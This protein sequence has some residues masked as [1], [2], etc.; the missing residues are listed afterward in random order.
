[1]LSSTNLVK[2]STRFHLGQVKI[3]YV[4][5]QR[6][7]IVYTLV[8]LLI[9]SKLVTVISLQSEAYVQLHVLMDF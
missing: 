2:F 9:L 1:L 8:G 3:H 6:E 7:Y 5:V 4:P